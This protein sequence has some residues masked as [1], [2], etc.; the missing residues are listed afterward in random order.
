M[1]RRPSWQALVGKAIATSGGRWARRL[2][3]W[4]KDIAIGE[5]IATC[6]AASSRRCSRSA[7]DIAIGEAIATACQ[8]TRDL[9]ALFV[10]F[11]R[12]W[13]TG[14]VGTRATPSDTSGEYDA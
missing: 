9:P 2:C 11:A 5:V 14:W 3:C 4:A 13:S 8:E 10:P 6:T 1:L 12:T 7:N